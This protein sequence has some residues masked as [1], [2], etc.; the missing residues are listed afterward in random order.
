MNCLEKYRSKLIREINKNLS[1]L[2]DTADEKAVHDFR[3]GIKRLTA[4]Y[5]FLDGIDA[6]PQCRQLLKPW[7]AL[8]KS[9]GNIRDAQIATDLLRDMDGIDAGNS[10]SLVSAL[11]SKITRDYHAFGDITRHSARTSIRMPTIRSMG[12]SERAI[13]RYKPVALNQ[14]LEQILQSD[15]RMNAKRWHKKRILLK[16]YHHKLDAFGFCPGHGQDETELKQIK[17]LE[18]LLGD[19]HDRVVTAELLQSLPG[20]ERQADQTVALMKKQETLLL[21]SAQIYLRKFALWQR[22][23]NIDATGNRFPA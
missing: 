16:R 15:E 21:G 3:V 8:F 19:W 22:D 23:K 6:G 11:E 7:R 2:F 9:S 10:K 4:L 18:Q 17:M 1:V 13:L 12:I 14:L 20:I 5:Y